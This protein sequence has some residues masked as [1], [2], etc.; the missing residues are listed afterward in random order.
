MTSKTK[1]INFCSQKIAKKIEES[2]S[3][4][5]IDRFNLVHHVNLHKNYKYKSWVKDNKIIN[6]KIKNSD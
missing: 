3:P 2:Y 4:S 5:F 6:N 1:K